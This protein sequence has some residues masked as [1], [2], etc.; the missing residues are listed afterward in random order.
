MY[1]RK[2]KRTW[3]RGKIGGK[4]LRFDY[5]SSPYGFGPVGGRA[6]GA[7]H[8]TSQ[9]L[10]RQPGYLPDRMFTKVYTPFTGQIQTGAAGA[11]NSYYL[12]PNSLLVPLGTLSSNTPGGLSK[13]LGASACYRSYIVHS[14]A[15]DIKVMSVAN[16]PLVAQF[17]IL[18]SY[19]L[20]AAPASMTAI[21]QSPR[22]KWG[23]TQYL[24]PP[25]R[26]KGFW[27]SGQLYGQSPQT[28]AIADSFSAL[29]SATPASENYIH[30]GFDEQAH[31]TQMLMG[32]QLVLTQYIELFGRN[33]AA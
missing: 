7:G 27:R 16:T 18:P 3:K 1:T 28:V 2:R 20:A 19:A 26:L 22:A 31:T 15:I 25:L 21:M 23:C 6:S 10:I 24:V 17:G 9:A 4:R 5:K 12:R 8:T 33:S 14:F 32:L 30:V 29:Y 11:Y 13:L